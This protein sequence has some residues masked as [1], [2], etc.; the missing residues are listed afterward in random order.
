MTSNPALN[1]DAVRRPTSLWWRQRRALA[2]RWTSLVTRMRMLTPFLA[3]ILMIS[4]SVRG[5]VPDTGPIPEVKDSQIGYA[6]VDEAITSLKAKPGV[7]VNVQG[8]WT[9]I[10]DGLT[11]WSFTPAG[12]PAHPAAVKRT[13]V[14]RD[15]A[16]YLEMNILC[17]A[18]KEACDKLARDFQELNNQMRADMERRRK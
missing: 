4:G 14:E 16:W 6:T 13:A 18:S 9:I 17:G 1:R 8:G 11:L 3:T 15:G 12:N 7:K 2:P 5:Q 10:G